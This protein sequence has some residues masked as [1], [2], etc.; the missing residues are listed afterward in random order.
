MENNALIA[1]MG[2]NALIADMENNALIADME[3]NAS[4][5]MGDH[6]SLRT[7]SEVSFHCKTVQSAQKRHRILSA[8][9]NATV[10]RRNAVSAPVDNRAEQP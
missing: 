2:N 5:A 4:S 7:S 1:D 9:I 6:I 3:N 10:F 8:S